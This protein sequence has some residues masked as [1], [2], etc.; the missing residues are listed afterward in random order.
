M[1]PEMNV[2]WD[3]K[4]KRILILYASIEIHLINKTFVSFSTP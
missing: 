3:R 1:L 2:K 4:G